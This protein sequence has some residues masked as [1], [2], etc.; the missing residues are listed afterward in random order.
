MT[1]IKEFELIFP[2]EISQ[3]V[4]SFEIKGALML[5]KILSVLILSSK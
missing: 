4:V 3:F 5:L 2:M 1:V